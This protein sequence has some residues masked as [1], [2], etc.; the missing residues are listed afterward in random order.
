M[1]LLL[2]PT[3]LLFIQN[4]PIF[5]PLSSPCSLY[6]LVFCF[7]LQTLHKRHLLKNFGGST[8]STQCYTFSLF[9]HIFSH[10]YYL[11]TFYVIFFTALGLPMLP[12]GPFQSPYDASTRPPSMHLPLLLSYYCSCLIPQFRVINSL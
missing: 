9:V 12:Q 3:T 2:Q 5:K 4:L 10:Y 6:L 1:I 8:H 11:V 7:S